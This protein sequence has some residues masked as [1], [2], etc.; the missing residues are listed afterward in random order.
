[1]DIDVTVAFPGAPVRKEKKALIGVGGGRE[2]VQRKN[3]K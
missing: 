1:M 2:R 3:L